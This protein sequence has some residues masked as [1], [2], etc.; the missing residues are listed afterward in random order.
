MKLGI[1]RNTCV[2][3][4]INPSMVVTFNIQLQPKRDEILIY[5]TVKCFD[6]R[7]HDVEMR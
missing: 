2:R 1:L 3:G 7:A 6:D 4:G 5:S